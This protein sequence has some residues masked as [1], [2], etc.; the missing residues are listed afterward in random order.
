MGHS[1][2]LAGVVCL[3]MGSVCVAQNSRPGD[4]QFSR[5]NG[6]TIFA[7]YSNT[8]S[9]MLM[10]GSRQRELVTMGGAYTRRVVRFWGSQ[11]NYQAE[12]RPI[13][14][15]SDPVANTT[16]TYTV[17]TGN[18]P[19]SLTLTGSE[20]T[21][22]VCQPSSGT[23]PI[24]T[25]PGEPAETVTYSTVCGRQWTFGQSFSPL[26]FKYSL[27]T[28]RRVQPFIIGTLGYMYSSRPIP[29]P[30]AEAFNFAFDFG[31]GVEM[32]QKKRRSISL[33]CRLHHFSNRDTAESNPG[34]DNLMYKLSY[35]FGR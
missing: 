12:I 18:P 2:W 29:V 8:S 5:K 11:L 1:R 23:S 13:V 19:V 25:P 6:W 10:G 35:S 7:E 20:A 4:E 28:R 27:L 30:E 14:F 17:E 16:T 33:E 22:D 21:I 24:T 32:Y 26:G 34:V 15:E 31:A 3:L 9:H